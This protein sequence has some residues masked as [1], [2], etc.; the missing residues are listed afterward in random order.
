MKNSPRKKRHE[1]RLQKQ[2]DQLREKI[3]CII[4]VIDF[5]HVSTKFLILN[6][7]KIRRSRLVQEKKLFN[8]GYRIANESNNPEKVVFNFS[9][10]QL[11]KNEKS[12]LAKELNLSVPPKVLNYAD[13][14]HPFEQAY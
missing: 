3:C 5:I 2:F 7:R 9:N 12:L 1:L 4:R 6:D 11:N 13:F 8:L 14:L 10:R